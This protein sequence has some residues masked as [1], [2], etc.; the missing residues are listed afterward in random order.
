MLL[1]HVVLLPLEQV[2]QGLALQM[3]RAG[4][5]WLVA[6]MELHQAMGLGQLA[7]SPLFRFGTFGVAAGA[8]TG[9]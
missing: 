2:A 5:F 1:G 8:A 4:R 7:S 6:L 9:G 3:A